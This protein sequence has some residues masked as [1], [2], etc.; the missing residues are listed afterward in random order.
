M[1]L[2][3]LS[4][5]RCCR[6]RFTIKNGY[7]LTSKTQ[8]QQLQQQR[9]LS[10]QNAGDETSVIQQ[11][12]QRHGLGQTVILV[13]Q[14]IEVQELP[15]IL[16][17]VGQNEIISLCSNEREVK[18]LHKDS[19]ESRTSGFQFDT[20]TVE[21]RT[22]NVGINPV[23][24]PE[25]II[26]FMEKCETSESLLEIIEEVLTLEFDQ[27]TLVFAL[28]KLIRINSLNGLK[29]LELSN[30]IYQKLI[31][32]FCKRCD[33]QELLNL[34]DQLRSRLFMNQTI[35]KVCDELLLRSSDG[36]LS[37]IEICESIERFA[38]CKR[39]D[40][41][42]KF[43]SG[44]SDQDNSITEQNITFVYQVLERLKVSRRMVLG[45][46]DRKIIDVFPLLNSD[47]VI[48]ILMALTRCPGIH[49]KCTLKSLSRWL[50]TNIHAVTETDLETIIHSMTQLQY[51]DSDIESALERYM[52]AKATQISA[53]TLIVDIAKH[54][55]KFRLL[56]VHIL[57]GISEFFIKN[58][59][60]I[61]TGYI[62][63]IL[64]PF[65]V[66]CYP[67]LNSIQFWQTLEKYLATNFD[68]IPKVEIIDIM[69]V[70]IHLEIYPVNFI[71]RV[72]NRYFMHVL[73]SRLPLERLAVVRQNLKLLD[74]AMTL[75]CKEYRGP[76]LPRDLTDNPLLIDNRI[77]CVI[78]DNNDLIT[79]IAGGADS[80][81]KLTVPQKLPYNSLYVIDI[82]FHPAGMSRLWN[83][84]SI[85]DRDVYVAA[86]IHLPEHYDSSQKYLSGSQ[87][88]RI[89]HL[90][91]IGLKVVS[92]SYERLTRLGIHQKEL[93]EYVVA[94]MKQ[95]LPAIDRNIN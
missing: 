89:R 47:A 4:Q 44:I 13:Q 78:N 71:D 74:T 41:A 54:I 93:H 85:D 29:T 43:W 48:D 7:G 14:G 46:L 1:S 38:E 35:H 12:Q 30:S 79:M 19:K 87:K 22:P 34:L 20:N 45:I 51:S 50:N 70:A 17:R 68:R 10:D 67:P 32:T 25:N 63:D 49:T 55:N 72:F 94:Q 82:L 59:A 95:A 37:I 80:F 11:H 21:K 42:E 36:C 58:S 86:L 57:N 60:Q 90:R 62:R 91:H 65:G 73:H 76:M 33:T 88:M 8:Q 64:Q 28:D 66:M 61:N 2:L 77:K 39:F 69:L 15:F 83:F 92:L 31:E 5:L 84:N 27:E 52:K 40:G 24:D 6:S 53:Q 75:E 81:T 16:R 18:N 9:F 3:I 23:I 26:K 56:N